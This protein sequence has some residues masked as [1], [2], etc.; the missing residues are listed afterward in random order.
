MF[1]SFFKKSLLLVVSLAFLFVAQPVWAG[2]SSASEC[3]E[4]KFGEKYAFYKLYRDGL[5]TIYGT[6]LETGCVL[7]SDDANSV[8]FSDLVN[9]GL[10]DE[11]WAD[12]DTNKKVKCPSS[13]YNEAW[14][15]DKKASGVAYELQEST[16]D[17]SCSNP[18]GG[19][20]SGPFPMIYW[21][22]DVISETFG[23]A[24]ANL[25][26]QGFKHPT[27][28][29]VW[30]NT[31][32]KSTKI[33]EAYTTTVDIELVGGITFT[34]TNAITC[35]NCTPAIGITMVVS[36]TGQTRTATFTFDTNKLPEG[37]FKLKVTA[38]T[39]S[40]KEII[41]IPINVAKPDLCKNF[42]GD[43]ASC[44]KNVGTCFYY[45]NHCYAKADT[46]MCTSLPQELCGESAG[47]VNCSWSE[48]SNTCITPTQAAIEQEYTVPDGY[49]ENGGFLPP[50][51][52]AGN[53][54]DINVFV[55]LAINVTKFFFGFIGSLALVMFVYGG[56][57]MILSFGSAEK[58]KKGQQILV[59]AVVGLFI[60][61]G[62]YVLVDFVLDALNVAQSFRE[63]K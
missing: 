60:S 34:D 47:G 31:E 45:K 22:Q 18:A 27:G 38:N 54:R 53:C 10:L 48:A 36:G 15:F 4:P 61:F 50:C 40:G 37:I 23:N 58:V 43:E 6:L 39:V 9:A 33:G 30:K 49:I 29:I 8:V 12:D 63:I 20:H 5:T 14:D 51:A 24:D 52:F 13:G 44:K 2:P 16:K 57:T 25:I 46:H 59:A 11:D 19:Y 3:P 21:L 7:V 42:D 35:E 41:D 32:G 26:F 62:A 56:F 28:K 1:S 55:V 17:F